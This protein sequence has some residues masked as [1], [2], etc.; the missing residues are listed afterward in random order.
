MEKEGFEIKAKAG[1]G[2][3]LKMVHFPLGCEG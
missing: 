1:N 3:F 2:V